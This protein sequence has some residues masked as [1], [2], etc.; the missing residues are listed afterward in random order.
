MNPF[1][2]GVARFNELLA[3][4]LGVP[5]V[6][7]TEIDPARHSHPLLSFKVEELPEAEGAALGDSLEAWEPGSMSLFLH[8]YSELPLERRLLAVA[9][10]VWCGNDEVHSRVSHV[11]PD[12]VNV[13]APGL[14]GDTRPF[15]TPPLSVFSFGM[16][17]KI[18]LDMFERLRSLLDETG[19]DW[20]V[21][22]SAANHETRTIE[23]GQLV[24]DEIQEAFESGL[25]FLGNLSD[26]AVYNWLKQTTFFAAFFE[27]GVRANNTS[28]ASAMEHG[29]VVITNLDEHSPRD[30]VHMENMIDIEQCDALPM[31]PATLSSLARRA[32]E[33]ASQRD[34][35][36]LTSRFRA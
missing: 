26:V 11:H 17:H 12:A 14:I 33:T 25:F 10:R 9:K 2:S 32:A 6:R 5:L 18:R 4:R 1:T 15:G 35:S 31:E 3:G 21:Y 24:F 7:V 20:G 29:A 13:W 27:G 28:V 34:W 16:A 8:T 23:E 22:V 36:A 30:L 19:Q